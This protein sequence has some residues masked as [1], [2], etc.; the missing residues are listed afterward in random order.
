MLAQNILAVVTFVAV[1]AANPTKE[2]KTPAQTAANNCGNNTKLSCCNTIEKQL[3]GGLIPIQVGLGC[4]VIN[5]MYL[6]LIPFL[7]ASIADRT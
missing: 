7:G 3:L 6:D 1:A 5:G 2:K 4:T